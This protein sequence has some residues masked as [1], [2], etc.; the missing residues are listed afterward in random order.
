M[1]SLSSSPSGASAGPPGVDRAHVLEHLKHVETAAAEI[2]ADRDGALAKRFADEL[3]TRRE[4]GPRHAWQ[5]ARH[6]QCSSTA[7]I[8]VL[9]DVPH[10]AA[11]TPAGNVVTTPSPGAAM[12]TLLP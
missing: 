2:L 1:P 12:R 4:F 7:A 5:L 6:G 11:N 3:G 9:N 8:A 10:A